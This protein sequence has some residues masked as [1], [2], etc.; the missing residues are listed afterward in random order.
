MMVTPILDPVVVSIGSPALYP[1]PPLPVLPVD[2]QMPVLEAGDDP[3]P[4]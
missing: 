3:V 2:E 4:G 1:E